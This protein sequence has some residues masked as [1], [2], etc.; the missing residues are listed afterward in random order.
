M[1]EETSKKVDIRTSRIEDRIAALDDFVA[2]GYEVHLNFS[3]VI[4]HEGWLAD[5]AELLEQ[6]DAGTNDATK[7][8]LACEII[9]LT[10]NQGLHEVNLGWHPKGEELLWRPDLQQLK[11]SESGQWNVR[12][13]SGYKGR[14]VDQLT[15]LLA[16]RMPYCRVRYA[17]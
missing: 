9:F 12:Y 17:F 14:Y 1:P 5:W 10:H 7:R 11:R 6:I 16:E 8:Q 15:T 2:A 4:V 13:K 3:P